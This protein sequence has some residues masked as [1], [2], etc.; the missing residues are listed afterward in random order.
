MKLLPVVALFL[1][2]VAFRAA[3]SAQEVFN[4]GGRFQALAESSTSLAGL[5]SVYGNQAGLAAVKHI[6]V[7]GSF[8]NRFLV[9]ELSSRAG[10]FS[11]PFQENV[12]AASYCQ[13]GEVPFRQDKIGLAYARRLGGKL[14]FGLQFNRYGLYLAEENKSVFTH[15]LEVGIQ[16]AVKPDFILGIHLT[17]PYQTRIKLSSETYRY[18]SKINVGTFFQ[19]SGDFGW[20]LDF[21]NRFNNQVVVKSGFEYEIFKRLTI[22]S[23]VSGKPYSL[24]AGFGFRVGKMLFDFA[25]SYNQ[26]LGTSPCVSF[27][28]QIR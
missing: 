9:N 19:L 4:S 22:R 5:W 25:T 14:R 24:A 10:I 3:T 26:Y 8:Q 27:Q 12:F 16:Y 28:Y 20:T 7:A 1:V 17:N 6:E 2:L 18:E 21:E 13:F 23:G 11:I 15:G